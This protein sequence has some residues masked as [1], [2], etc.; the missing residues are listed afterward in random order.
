MRG[1]QC[2]QEEPRYLFVA[3]VGKDTESPGQTSIQERTV[4][5]PT[6]FTP[7][8]PIK[9]VEGLTIKEDEVMVNAGYELTPVSGNV[10]MLRRS[11]GG[12]GPGPVQ[13]AMDC[14]CSGGVGLC[15]K[16]QGPTRFKCIKPKSL[17][18]TGSCR[19]AIYGLQNDSRFI[20]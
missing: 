8:V 19:L 14:V 10:Y 15:T 7:K 4:P 13:V 11:I 12:G 5:P 1:M 9:G 3:D 18:C 16:T 6:Q 20:Y 2:A 17:P